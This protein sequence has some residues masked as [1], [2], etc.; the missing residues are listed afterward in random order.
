MD[1]VIVDTARDHFAA[2]REA[3]RRRGADY[4]EADFRRTFGQRND[5]IIRTILG[6]GITDDEIKEIGRAKEVDFRARLGDDVRALPGAVE[7][8]R[9]LDKAEIKLAV[10]SSAPRRNIDFILERLGVRDCFPAIVSGGDVTAGKPDPQVFLQAARRLGVPPAD[11]LVI[12]DAVAG[13]A[14][15]R[16]AGMRCL[17]VTTTN[18]REKLA[19]ADRVVDSLAEIDVDS[20]RAVFKN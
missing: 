20:L 10:A 15:A 8:I 11:C 3:F 12:E 7:L 19:A 4:T 13:V 17:A 18:P 9:A 5:T 6:E 2:W 1:G 16:R 14:A